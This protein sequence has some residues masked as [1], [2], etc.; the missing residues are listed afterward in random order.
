M[1]KEVP[2]LAYN[3]AWGAH[4]RAGGQD[5]AATGPFLAGVPQTPQEWE[6]RTLPMQQQLAEG[7]NAIPGLM[8][9]PAWGK[10]GY[11]AGET[12]LSKLTPRLAQAPAAVQTAANALPA[13]GEAVGNYLSRQTNVAMG[14]EQPG[15]V[16][17]I[18]SA[19]LP[20]IARGATSKP[21]L[22]RTPGAG[23]EQH[24][25]AAEKVQGMVEG[26]QPP[27]P[28]TLY[29]AVAQHHNPAIPAQSLRQTAQEIMQQKWSRSTVPRLGK[30]LGIAQEM[31]LLRSS[32]AIISRWIACIKRCNGSGNVL[33]A[34]LARMTLVHAN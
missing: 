34:P 3:A 4:V 19:A 30:V 25:M 1:L 6:A 2:G 27:H 12:I 32:I 21:V 10:A 28:H 22:S 29:Q 15:V 11:K 16:G 23:V 33:V 14:A 9:G 8:A 5:P 20:L 31:A 13:I 24:A 7:V 18:A 26:M 17:D